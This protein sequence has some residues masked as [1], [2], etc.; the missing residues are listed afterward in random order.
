ML[1]L[2]VLPALLVLLGLLVLVLVLALALALIATVRVGERAMGHRSPPPP[3]LVRLGTAAM[4]R[5]T[6]M[7][8][9][10]QSL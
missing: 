3:A 7:R 1:V 5:P 10:R 6:R 9:A 8:A 2:L 4:R